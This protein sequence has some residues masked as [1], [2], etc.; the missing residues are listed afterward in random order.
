MKTHLVRKNGSKE[1]FPFPSFTLQKYN[2]K[3]QIMKKIKKEEFFLK[4]FK[5]LK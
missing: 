1:L 3:I 2:G 5:K 4:N